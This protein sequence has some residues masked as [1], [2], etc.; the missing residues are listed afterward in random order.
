MPKLKACG[1]KPKPKPD[2]AGCKPYIEETGADTLCVG[3]VCKQAARIDAEP[4]WELLGCI[5]A[6]AGRWERLKRRALAFI[7]TV[8]SYVS[9]RCAYMFARA[10]VRM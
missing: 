10:V 2:T 4:A 6:R 9:R 3:I 7:A 5:G 1:F 8:F